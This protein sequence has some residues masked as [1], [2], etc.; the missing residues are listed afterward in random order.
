MTS[1]PD[2]GLVGR[3]AGKRARLYG[4]VSTVVQES[5]GYSLESQRTRARQVAAAAG[6]RVVAEDFEQ[7]SGQDWDLASVLDVIERAKRGEFDV[8]V[9]KNVSRLSRKR[10]KQAWLEH[11]L[12]EAGVEIYYNDEPYEDT[13]FGRLQRGL[14]AEI[15]E[16][17][18]EQARELSMEA[19]YDK[20]EQHGRPVGNGQTPYGWRR[21]RDESGLKRRTIGYVHDEAEAGVIRRF[22]ELKHT[23][24]QEFCDRLNAEGIPSRGKWRPTAKRPRS[25]KWTVSALWHV[26]NNTMT[27]GEYRYGERQ[28]V[29][30]H[31]KARVVKKSDAKVR[32]LS[33]PPILTREEVDEIKAA[34]ASRRNVR[35]RLRGTD[36]DPYI[37][38]GL[39]SCG[40]CG[41]ALATR[42]PGKDNPWRMYGCL[43]SVKRYAERD[44]KPLC[45]LPWLIAVRSPQRGKTDG[46]EEIVWSALKEGLLDGQHLRDEIR[47]SREGTDGAAGHA[48][49]LAFLRRLIQ[50]K[51]DAL[52]IATRRWAEA[53]DELDQAS[54]GATREALK[55]ELRSLTAELEQLEAYVPVGITDD[56]EAALLEFA[57]EI[58][59]G[60]DRAEPAD[61]QF[62]LRRL[63]VHGVVTRDPDGPY[64]IGKHRY[65]IEWTGLLDLGRFTGNGIRNFVNFE[66]VGRE[67]LLPRDSVIPLPTAPGL[68]IELDEDALRA[69]AHQPYPRCT[70]RQPADEP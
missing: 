48:E 27:W 16:F 49:R 9:L 43:R 7:G 2:A 12:D 58:Q 34:L 39:L 13:A 41:G 3:F 23:P 24:T 42:S 20:I 56:E 61:R 25:G 67:P 54:F 22:H 40:H 46:V 14:M 65:A 32:T 6:M 5:D 57:A 31:G 26:L 53:E 50:R 21:V 66:D 38:R 37:L 30:R 52:G 36:A 4:R 68:G 60:L 62:V 19:R 28:L 59:S 64:L 63:R 1:I 51:T 17:Q 47:R 8:L 69:R 11:L 44:G 55:R 29:R 33:L 10:G 18:L 70:L 45:V 15:A 35:R